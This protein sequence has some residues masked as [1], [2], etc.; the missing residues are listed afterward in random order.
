MVKEKIIT[1]ITGANR[2]MGLEI[3]KELGHKGQN[4]LI[5]SRDLSKGQAV[6]DQLVEDNI[7]TQ[8]VQ[9]DV[10]S[11][12]SIVKAVQKITNDY[13]YLSIL[14]NNAGAVFD[15]GQYPS[16]ITQVN[17]RQNFEVNYFGLVDVTQNFLPLLAKSTS[18]KIINVS[19]MMGSI[20][21]ALNPNSAVYNAV[22]VGYQSSK[23][24]V[25]MYTVQLAKEMQRKKL[26][27]SVNAI[28]PGMVAT[29]FGNLDPEQA[30]TMG[31]IPVEKGVA[32]T[33]EM[34]ISQD[35]IVTG[36]FSDTNGEV[37]W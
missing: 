2:G 26:S 21:E 36:T 17:L 13:G 14:I 24:A 1:L 8:A 9:L 19:S 18:A 35:N 25:N 6:A 20:T 27:I 23:S 11:H 31:A 12:D 30:K 3:A 15:Y 7:D 5:G 29:E 34:A 4:V 10:T 33:V 37:N 28:N 22:A 16:N 32:R